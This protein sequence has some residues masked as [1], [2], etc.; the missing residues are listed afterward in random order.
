MANNHS[1]AR[2]KCFLDWSA[3]EAHNRQQKNNKLQ[4]VEI[5]TIYK[6]L[7]AQVSIDHFLS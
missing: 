2:V 4:V 6:I 5:I 3:Y 7:N 1:V